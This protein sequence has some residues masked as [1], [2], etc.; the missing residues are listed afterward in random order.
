MRFV[1]PSAQIIRDDKDSTS[2][3]FGMV[4]QNCPY[5]MAARLKAG[6]EVFVFPAV[7]LH[8]VLHNGCN[9][10]H[11][12]GEIDRILDHV[13]DGIR[14][15]VGRNAAVPGASIGHDQRCD[16]NE[17]ST[18]RGSGKESSRIKELAVS[19]FDNDDYRIFLSR[20]PAIRQ[21]EVVLNRM[22][23]GGLELR[24]TGIIIQTD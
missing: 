10:I 22:T 18:V 1:Y 20:D 8:Y 17:T 4:E 11:I 7:L 9:A 19:A 3:S 6:D 2:C 5:C 16:K 12:E 23:G 24:L 15:M 14:V 21:R 13:P